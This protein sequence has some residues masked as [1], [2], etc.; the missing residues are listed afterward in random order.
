MHPVITP[1]QL[2]RAL[3]LRDLSDPASGPHAIQLVADAIGDAL[4]RAWRA[5]VPVHR[6]SLSSRSP[7]T[8]RR[9]AIR[10]PPRPARPATRA[11]STTAGCCGRT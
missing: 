10:P 7:T 4:Q 11:T 2:D 1:Q 8:T 6:A 9:S 5:P 3:A